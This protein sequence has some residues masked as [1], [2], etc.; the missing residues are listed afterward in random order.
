MPSAWLMLCRLLAVAWR[1]QWSELVVCVGVCRALGY[2]VASASGPVV[3]DG[4][5]A[6]AEAADG[7][8]L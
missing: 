5:E 8:A 3:G 1:A 4:G 6:V 7:V 2:K